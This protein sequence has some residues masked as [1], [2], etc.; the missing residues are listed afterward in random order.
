MYKANKSRLEYKWIPEKRDERFVFIITAPSVETVSSFSIT[1]QPKDFRCDGP[2]I[3]HPISTD[4]PISVQA[5][6]DGKKG[7]L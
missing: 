3:T 4:A 7:S 5:G 6:L 2:R 1:V